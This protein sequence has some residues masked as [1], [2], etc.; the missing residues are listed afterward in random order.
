MVQGVWTI[1]IP[2]GKVEEHQLFRICL[3]G[4]EPGLPCRQVVP[5]GRAIPILL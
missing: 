4:K 3:T 5:L 2:G 1:L